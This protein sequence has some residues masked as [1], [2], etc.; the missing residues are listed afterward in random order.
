MRTI[1][2]TIRRMKIT[3]IK[4]KV[5]NGQYTAVWDFSVS[6]IMGEPTVLVSF[7][8]LWQTPGLKAKI[9]LAYTSSIINGSLGR[10]SS[11]NLKQRPWRNALCCIWALWGSQPSHTAQTICLGKGATAANRIR[12][13]QLIVKMTPTDMTTG[14]PDLGNPFS[15]CVN[16]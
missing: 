1:Q 9:Y 7:L 14:L 10:S 3:D 5:T 8:V 11:R 4:N 16:W 13:H 15:S 12:Q 2:P 6:K